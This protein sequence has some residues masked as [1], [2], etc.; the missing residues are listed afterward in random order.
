MGKLLSWDLLTCST[1]IRVAI[2]RIISNN[3]TEAPRKISASIPV[4]GI[5]HR[6]NERRWDSMRQTTML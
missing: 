3:A 1:R 4:S 2:R 6:G 5:T